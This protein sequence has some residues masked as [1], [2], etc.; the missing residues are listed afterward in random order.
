M[1]EIAVNQKI[2]QTEISTQSIQAQK[3]VYIEKAPIV[4][5]IVKTHII[6]EVQPEVLQKTIQPTIVKETV[7]IQEKVNCHLFC[8]LTKKI[9]ESVHT[10]VVVEDNRK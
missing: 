5:E 1:S 2:A 10:N 6:E 8:K 3:D 9:V 4:H 7:P